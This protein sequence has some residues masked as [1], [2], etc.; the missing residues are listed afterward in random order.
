MTIRIGIG[1]WSYEP[2]RGPFYPPGTPQRRKLEYAGQHLTAIEINSTFYGSQNP[3]NYANR[4]KAVPDGFQFSV[5][6]SRCATARK[7]LTEGGDSI[8]KF[9]GQGIAEL[10]DRR[11]PILWQFL[12]SKRFDREDFARFLYLIPD[13]QDGAARRHALEPRHERFRDPAFYDLARARSWTQSSLD[14][15][16][17]FIAS[18][19]VRNP[20]AA[21][22]LIGK[23]G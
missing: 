12:A 16:I 8:Q 4:A 2:R 11:G 20:A 6:A 19:K 5:T 7:V 23:L 3:W 9:V 13:T 17:F 22:A 15:Y 18:A 10:S 1:G 21:Q 14:A